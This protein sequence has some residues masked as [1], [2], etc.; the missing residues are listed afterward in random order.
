MAFDVGNFKAGRSLIPSP[1]IATIL[2]SACKRLISFGLSSGEQ[3]VKM[4]NSIRPT[5]AFLLYFDYHASI[6]L[7]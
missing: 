4:L 5:T 6:I 1:A 2:P 3:Y 7:S